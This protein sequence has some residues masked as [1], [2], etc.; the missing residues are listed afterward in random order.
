MNK[1]N[2]VLS[3]LI[4]FA[5]VVISIPGI[6]L[7]SADDNFATEFVIV[8]NTEY[9]S[10]DDATN[11]SFPGSEYVDVDVD[12][13]GNIT[14][15]Q[16]K[17]TIYV[18]GSQNQIRTENLVYT[19]PESVVAED[20]ANRTKITTNNYTGT[21]VIELVYDY[22]ANDSAAGLNQKEDGSSSKTISGSYSLLGIGDGTTNAIHSRITNKGLA[23]TNSSQSSFGALSQF[24][25]TASGTKNGK[26]V[27]TLNTDALT[28]KAE[29]GG[30]VAETTF[31]AKIKYISQI[32]LNNMQRMGE[33]TKATI[34]SVNVTVTPSWTD[35]EKT[36][37]N[38]T[39]PAKLA[40]DVNNVTGNITLPQ[41]EGIVWTSSNPDAI[42]DTGVVTKKVGETQEVTLTATATVDG[43]TY[44]KSYGMTVAAGE[45]VEEPEIPT[46]PETPVEPDEPDEPYEPEVDEDAIVD[47]ID[48]ASVAEIK[49]W[50]LE[51]DKHV[52]LEVKDGKLYYNQLA[53]TL[54]T[55]AGK[56]NTSE[57]KP[58]IY[59]FPAV[60]VAEDAENNTKI[61]TNNYR[62]Q[63]DVT[64]TYDINLID[65][66]GN[67]ELDPDGI[68]TF[69]SYYTT[70]VGNDDF[71]ANV[72]NRTYSSY[73]VGYI[74]KTAIFPKPSSISDLPTNNRTVKYSLNTTDRT[75]KITAEGSDV[76]S[77]STLADNLKYVSTFRLFGPQRHVTGSYV[78]I[79]KISTKVVPVALTDAELSA[80]NSLV[81]VKLD[82]TDSPLEANLKVPVIDGV[83]WTSSNEDVITADGK[84]TKT[85]G[86][87]TTAN[88]IATFVVDGITYN[89]EY[90]VSVAP[91]DNFVTYTVDGEVYQKLEVKT[92][93]KASQ[94]PAPSITGMTFLGWFEEGASESF[95]FDT[96]ITDD[97][98]LYAKYEVSTYKVYFRVDSF[99][100]EELTKSVTYGSPVGTLPAVP[101][102][103]GLPVIG[104][105]IAGGNTDLLTE[106]TLISSDI[107][108]DATY[109]ERTGTSYTVTFV[110]C[111]ETVA[112][113]K[114]WPGY[115][116]EFPEAPTKENYSFV[117][118][119][120]NGVEFKETDV[121][122]NKDI[123]LE[124]VFTP[125]P[126]EVKF[127]SDETTLY[128]TGTGYYDTAY[129]AMPTAPTKNGQAF[130]YWVYENGDRF[131]EESVITGPLS[132]YA[133]WSE[134]KVI[135]NEDITKYTSLTEGVIQFE[136]C[137]TKYTALSFEDG[138]KMTMKS[139]EPLTEAGAA[140]SNNVLGF[141]ATLR[142]MIDSD[143]ALRTKTYMNH[144]VGEYE[145]EFTYDIS[146]IRVKE[147]M[148][149]SLT[150][151]YMH[152]NIGARYDDG[153]FTTAPY[154]G[155][156]RN[157]SDGG[158]SFTIHGYDENKN[159]KQATVNMTKNVLEHK[160]TVHFNTYTDKATAWGDNNSPV[161]GEVLWNA[162]PNFI[163]GLNVSPILR[164]GVG[165]YFKL[166][167]VKITEFSTDKTSQ[168]YKET[169][170]LIEQLPDSLVA[171]PFAVTE[172]IEM[173]QIEGIEWSTTDSSIVNTSGV[174]NRWYDDL[175]VVLTATA[176]STEGYKYTKEYAL[177]I[178]AF[179][180]EKEIIEIDMDTDSWS[181][182]NRADQQEAKYSFDGDAIKVEKVT[183]A[184][185]DAS[186]KENK[187]YYA[188]YDLYS[189]V[190]SDDYT[191]TSTNVYEGVY[192]VELDI[193]NG[194]TSSVPMNIAI[195]YKNGDYFFST[196]TVK[197][198]GKT[199]S[200]TYPD[201][202]E[203]TADALIY[204]ANIKDA[205][206][207]IRIDAVNNT[208]SAWIDGKIAFRNIRYVT[209]FPVSSG[210]D[211][212]STIRV[213]VDTNNN[214][215]DYVVIKDIGMQK[216]SGMEIASAKS[217][218]SVADGITAYSVTNTP[219][220]VSGNL[221]ALPKKIGEYNIEWKSNSNQVDVETSEVFFAETE[222]DV[223][224]TAYITNNNIEYP[225]IVKKDFKLHLRAR[226]SDAE[227]GEYLINSL[228]KIT[229]Q[230]YNEIRYDLNLPVNGD[231]TWTSSNPAL[232][233]AN[234]KINEEAE[235][236]EPTQVKMT[237]SAY[238]S[239][240]EYKL[241]VLPRTAQNTL[242]SG[243]A[244]ATL[245]YGSY[246]DLKTSA[247]TIA[248]FAI[249]GSDA[250]GK[251]NILDEKD[252]VIVS[253]IIEDGMFYFDYKGSEYK[254]YE[255]DEGETKNFKIITMPETGKLAII[256]DGVITDDYVDFKNAANY[257]AKVEV[258]NPEI[259]LSGLKVTTDGYGML[260][261]N[262]D[263]L[264]YFSS[265]GRGVLSGN[266]TL[267]TASITN[268][269]VKWESANTGVITNTGVVT[270][271][272]NLAY[273]TL[274]F[275]IKD[276][277]NGNVHI[278]KTF[279]IIVECD[280]SKNIAN[281]AYVTVS[282]LEN[283]TYPK[284]NVND[285][286]FDSVY[287]IVSASTKPSDIVFDFG[288]E[289][290]MNTML[291]VE[292]AGDIRDFTLY[293]SKDNAEWNAVASGDMADVTNRTVKFDTLSTRYMKLTI[294]TSNAAT[295][296]VNEIKFYLF[297]SAEELAKL[298]LNALSLPTSTSK[299]LTLVTLGAYGTVFEWASSDENIISTT[300]EITKPSV[301]T[302][303]TLTATAVGTG[304]TRTFE[305]VVSASGSA[306]PE[307]I[308][309]GSSGGSGGGGGGSAG[310][311]ANTNV[312]VS[313]DLT[314]PVYT[315]D[316]KEE[317]EEPT[318]SA[319]TV[320][321]D[322][323]STDWYYEAVNTLTEKGIVS[324]DGTGYFYPTN[325]VTREQFVK[326]ILEAIEV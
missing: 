168:G 181:F 270:V 76:E 155:R 81:P 303:V 291:F 112:T 174:V 263:N 203:T 154:S 299:N 104:W 92:G 316:V 159:S 109:G 164:L 177:T 129:G 241:T 110:S 297:T 79:D 228:G 12:E 157:F 62:G 309:G 132:V 94:I 86:E 237:A 27:Y 30:R 65:P 14:Y 256:V 274:K 1:L 125:N 151:A 37:L 180:F 35:A 84:I 314:K 185:D 289:K 28:V 279:N 67:K 123:T 43:V 261:V 140:N 103:D 293:A 138:L 171:D 318:E 160:Y 136:E 46:E 200:L 190:S 21:V 85:K 294:E 77:K 88:L 282:K 4:C 199:I 195:G 321:T 52:G 202:G 227:Y 5:M 288:S 236:Y 201:S 50:S 276:R 176:T 292:D 18:N 275:D 217:A 251:V 210:I 324:G 218:L 58:L 72:V 230:N 41:G 322:V 137:A 119:E 286:D 187:T 69:V 34:D 126:V 39:L 156:L 315:E 162:T 175:D 242:Y 83:T 317:T 42:S 198:S 255:I 319:N 113:V 149:V 191:V 209:P 48:Y 281:G 2:R 134:P 284:T 116:F 148:G 165:S 82:G 68:I 102:K 20:E 325:N 135:A 117:Y 56:Q 99:I 249:T 38:V 206:L 280:N 216:I 213:G 231:I 239:T 272:D 146:T 306:G 250:E 87:V 15:T 204:P 211:M 277:A 141:A 114:A 25:G 45:E 264:D 128:L 205:K 142:A 312:T 304:L 259:M 223:I 207:R 97:V 9:A 139:W 19:L 208:L 150:E 17:Q 184:D 106:D 101:E 295:V 10:F 158:Q 311:S 247:T 89:K 243:V 16:T 222:K 166:K 75:V 127:Y 33:G 235:V 245:S 90:T 152:T 161:G 40:D 183:A 252:N 91:A 167:N 70:G 262:M 13:E 320:Y 310:G 233:G 145:V 234:G 300:G 73:I 131:T 189:E 258:T 215:G 31:P 100:Q 61:T 194:V 7:V 283:M 60:T 170:G 3:L 257:V 298:D 260:T 265:V 32:S 108:V 296:D 224:V 51:D 143:D 308:G 122:L 66:N 153:S 225:V 107:Y 169:M 130:Q 248:S 59:T 6:A 74:N 179:D 232:I 253:T 301:A 326:M 105:K 98:N 71:S 196:A 172:N 178:K 302:K 36:M 268:A 47:N 307:I 269:D 44:K 173:P 57:T 220:N 53:H 118:W 29:G 22:V 240:K 278:E 221:K 133:V 93:N 8:D 80:I 111:G 11:W 266:V 120:R 115:K 144:L 244:P 212:F 26:V 254:T 24:V 323:K 273:T 193:E 192:D 55:S 238:G 96:A 214:A 63:I 285:N 271:S 147:Y 313:P 163:N 305:V 229:N 78:A 290:L 49:N 219:D 197:V 124:A 64:V 186:V 95:D 23:H 121:M 182:A 267:P 226:T 54:F 287:R 246:T 188:Y